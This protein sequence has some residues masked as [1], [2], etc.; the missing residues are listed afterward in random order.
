MVPALLLAGVIAGAPGIASANR[1]QMPNPDF[2]KGESIPEGS[3]FDMT[4][5]ATGLRGW[6]YSRN[7][8]TADA[9][10]VAVTKVDAGSPAADIFQ[11]GDVLLGVAGKPFSSDP[12]V[13]L[14]QALTHA[15]SENGAGKLKL[16]RWRDGK[17]EEVELQLPVLGTYSAT[18][19][20]DCPKSARILGQGCEALA[21]VVAAPGYK[22]NP[23]SRSLNA[24]ALLASGN[25]EY[26]PL[27]EKE[28]EWAAGFSAT[29]MAT[30]YY[31]YVIMFLAEYHMITGDESVLPGLR[32]LALE[33]ANG[34][35]IVGSWGHAF[36]GP[37][38]RLI[39]YGMMNA[40]G[41]PLTTGI[42]MARMAG[43]EDPQLDLAVDRA[44]RMQR[45]YIGKGSVPYGDH[46]PWINAHEDNGKCAM[47]AVLY[48]L[49]EEKEGTGFFSR[50]TLAAHNGE[51]DAGHTGNFW[52]IAWAMPG[53][54]L[55]GPQA[56]GAWM[57]EFGAWYFDLARRWDGTFI[58]QSPPDKWR[59]KTA[60]WDA[61]G[62][63][64]IAYAM[65]LKKLLITGRAPSVV[66]QLDASQAAALIDDGRGW[67]QADP[68]GRYE[69]MSD[70]ELLNRLGSWSPVIRERAGAALARRANPP[71]ETIIAKLDATD[72]ETRLGACQAL[73]RFRAKAAPAIEPLRETLAADH[74]W[75]RVKAAEALCAIGEPALVAL[76]DL[77]EAITRAPDPADPRAMEQRFISTAVFGTLLKNVKSLDGVD[78]SHLY[79]AIRA[80]LRNEDGRARGTVSGIYPRL[81]FEQIKP[82][83]PAIV[84]AI[85]TPAPSGIMFADG[86]R[87]NGLHL[88]ADH[89]IEEGMALSLSFLDLDRWGKGS[90]IPGCLDALAKY[91]ASAAPMLPQLLQLEQD[92]LN[93][94]E[95]KSNAGIRTGLE[96]ARAIIKTIE[97]GEPKVEL[98]RLAE[99]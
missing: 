35:S 75:L 66:P 62:A 87:L 26:L 13:E 70:D 28:A 89:Q 51:R 50:M 69:A 36:A 31:G 1:N 97:A 2:T 25:P 86:V 57:N 64:L 40:P 6:M 39:G 47:A 32:R 81:G 83:L 55:S 91:G 79:E 96:K 43:I 99:L 49:Q 80:G 84:E 73:A 61:T 3:N 58:H 98:R 20:Y 24:L 37:D 95:I 78:K 42:V 72:L 82:L 10:Q 88:L 65:P 18:A 16:T 5:G 45:F 30:W 90:R 59:D 29:G 11:S 77:L 21:K 60:G 22:S 15:E 23:I 74:Y 76:P 85:V 93:H 27:L 8:S 52:N 44:M 56:T 17:S 94:R 48:N 67:S 34:Q 4:L 7:L 9:R 71:L 41:L 14:G 54:N 63:Y 33:A 19:P 46:A 38:G 53:V 68:L 12:R 92:L